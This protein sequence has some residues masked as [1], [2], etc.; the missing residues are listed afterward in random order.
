MTDDK[1]LW[2]AHPEY[3][4]LC[5]LLD[6]VILALDD[7]S[8]S[9]GVAALRQSLSQVEPAGVPVNYL[10][11]DS[12]MLRLIE[13]LNQ[14]MLSALRNDKYDA[15]LY[16]THLTEFLQKLKSI[17]PSKDARGR[18]FQVWWETTGHL[19]TADSANSLLQSAVFS[20]GWKAREESKL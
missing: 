10:L 13:L 20:A 7:L 19:L 1:I 9:E 12:F 2:L 3:K 4:A 8:I 15:V 17:Q 18:A 11:A 5:D 14:A 6:S 16:L